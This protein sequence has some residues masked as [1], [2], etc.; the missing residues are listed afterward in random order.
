ME[1]NE[2]YGEK[3]L[4]RLEKISRNPIQYIPFRLEM[5]RSN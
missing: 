5:Q 2:I 3:I 4:H 1:H